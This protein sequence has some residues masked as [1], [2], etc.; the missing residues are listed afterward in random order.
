[1]VDDDIWIKFLEN[2][3]QGADILFPDDEKDDP[4]FTVMDQDCE[5]D[6]ER[7]IYV[8]S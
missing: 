2:L 7:G 4:D 8:P 3:N 1:M 6:Y 5:F